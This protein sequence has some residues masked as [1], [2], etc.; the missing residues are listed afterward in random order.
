[1]TVMAMFPLGSNVFPHQI[2]PL[3]V[4]EPR[5]RAMFEELSSSASPEFG[6]VL[7]ER[8]HEVGG[9]EQRS[10]VGT[11][12]RV[13]QSEQFDDGRWAVIAAGIERLDVI[14]WLPDNPYPQAIVAPRPVVDNGGSDLNELQAVVMELSLIH[15]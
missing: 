5:Y 8:G 14:E 13:L 11:R 15:I 12:V 2:M 10:T 4:F 7:I 3:H 1:M 9:N 6:I